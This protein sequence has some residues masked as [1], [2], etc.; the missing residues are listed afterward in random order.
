MIMGDENGMSLRDY[1]AAHAPEPPDYVLTTINI[2]D[3]AQ[4]AQAF[5]AWRWQYADAMLAEREKI[6]R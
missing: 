3:H 2:N 6:N 5:A 1:F 4:L